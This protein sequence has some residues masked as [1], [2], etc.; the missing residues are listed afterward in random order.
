MQQKNE[1]FTLVQ[2]W[3][4]KFVFGICL[5]YVLAGKPAILTG[6]PW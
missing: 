1:H 2:G 3:C 4:S 5:V 6:L